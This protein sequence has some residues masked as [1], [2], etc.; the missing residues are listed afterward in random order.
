MWPGVSHNIRMVEPPVVEEIKMAALSRENKMAVLSR[1]NKM[2]ALSRE[3]KM[4]ALSRENKMAAL[5]RENKM[6]TAHVEGRLNIL[7]GKTTLILYCLQSYKLIMYTY[8]LTI[9]VIL[10]KVNLNLYS[11]FGYAS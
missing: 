10:W 1:E 3:N 6:A 11:I 9:L 2:A 8:Y 5:S 7:T 4:A